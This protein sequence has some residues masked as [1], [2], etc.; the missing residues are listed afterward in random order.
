VIRRRPAAATCD[1]SNATMTSLAE[2]ATMS[3][4]V[5]SCELCDKTFT[6][7]S[8]L[9]RHTYQH[10]GLRPFQCLVCQRAFKHKHHLTEHSRLHSGE[11]PYCC[12]GCHKSFTHS[13]SYS[14][15]TN[16][17]PRFR[18]IGGSG[19]LEADQL[20]AE[21]GESSSELVDSSLQRC[22]IG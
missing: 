2:R 5:H 11:K 19:L 9:V 16:N 12:T 14:Q 20:L 6:K 15:H 8:S 4:R 17:C 7:H 22:R 3:H 13:G 21:S 10:S 1:V 18:G